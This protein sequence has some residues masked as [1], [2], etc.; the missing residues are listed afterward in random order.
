[1]K[2]EFADVTPVPKPVWWTAAIP[3]IRSLL[4]PPEA[5]KVMSPLRTPKVHVVFLIFKVLL[6]KA[7]L[8]LIF[9]HAKSV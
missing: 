5:L 2:V 7:D 4:A 6:H 3:E 9:L 1:M 8:W